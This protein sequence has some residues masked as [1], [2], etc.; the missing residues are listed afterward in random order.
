MLPTT[1][2][3]SATSA[4]K[5]LSSAD[6]PSKQAAAAARVLTEEVLAEHNK[7]HGSLG[8]GTGTFSVHTR[9][10][11]ARWVNENKLSCDEKPFEPGLVPMEKFGVKVLNEPQYLQ[12]KYTF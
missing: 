10:Y 9:D 11:I 5:S 8:C 4:A 2:A 1:T 3:S 7:L 6:S 12:N